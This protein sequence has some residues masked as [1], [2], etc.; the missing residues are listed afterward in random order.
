MSEYYKPEREIAPGS[1]LPEDLDLAVW[2]YMDFWKFE[3]I[4]KKRAIYLCR[5][6]N[7]QQD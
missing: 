4:I 2:H 7:L 1:E 3:S 6:D 5:G